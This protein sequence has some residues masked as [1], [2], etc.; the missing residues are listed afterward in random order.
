MRLRGGEEHDGDDVDLGGLLLRG[1]ARGSYILLVLSGMVGVVGLRVRLA[2]LRAGLGQGIGHMGGGC[3]EV[4]VVVDGEG[5]G[6]RA[7][8]RTARVVLGLDGPATV[9][10]DLDNQAVV[11]PGDADGVKV[12]NHVVGDAAGADGVKQLA[13]GRGIRERLLRVVEAEVFG[14]QVHAQRGRLALVLGQHMLL[15][16]D[17]ARR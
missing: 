1:M 4:V 11:V 7:V 10:V 17:C 5:I 3:D 13:H 9:V 2:R 12:V 14:V 8:A 15:C 16:V 6:A